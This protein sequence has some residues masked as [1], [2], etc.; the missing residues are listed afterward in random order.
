MRTGISQNEFRRLIAT[1]LCVLFIYLPLSLIGLVT[2]VDTP[3]TPFVWAIVHGPLWKIIVYENRPVAIWNSW[4]GV[5]LAFTQ[6]ALI[7]F[8]RNA[9]R[10]YEHCVE[11][12]YYHL[13]TKLQDKLPSLGKFAQGCR[14]RR[15]AEA[16]ASGNGRN[17]SMVEPYLL[18]TEAFLIARKPGNQRKA[19]KNWFDSDEDI[20]DAK[21]LH[22]N[23]SSVTGKDEEEGAGQQRHAEAFEPFGNKGT[24]THVS[25]GTGPTPG[26]AHGV[27]VTRQVIVETSSR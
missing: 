14:E 5:A 24:T 8:T 7:G 17:V 21:S 20:E 4:I 19:V 10:F 15:A 6:F 18:M 12:G 16:I 3:M 13:P 25:A 11:L 1:V 23:E 9:R 26:W 22:S 2:S 27:K